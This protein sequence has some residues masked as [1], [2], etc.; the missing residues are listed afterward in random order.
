MAEI[1]NIGE[2]LKKHGIKPSYQRMKTFE[3]LLK[4]RNHP[5]V[6]MIYKELINEIPTLSKTTIYNTLKIFVEKNIVIVINIEDNEVRYDADISKHGHFKCDKC[7]VIYDFEINLG[8]MELKEIEAFR[9]DEY[10]F[11]LRGTCKKCIN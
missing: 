7:G 6:D 3:Y 10:H 4:Y 2:Y 1:D 11:Y 9:I 8:E 5:T